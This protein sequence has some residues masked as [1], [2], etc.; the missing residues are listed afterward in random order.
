[1]SKGTRVAAAVIRMAA[2]VVIAAGGLTGGPGVVVAAQAPV[3]DGAFTIDQAAD[4]WSVYGVQCGQCHGPNL[5]GMIHAPPLSGV[6]FLNSWLGQTTDDMFAYL[7]DEM[8]PGQAGV[9]S[10]Q[11]YVDLVAYLLESN[12]AVPGDRTLMAD[13]GVPIGDAAD[14]E[15][16]RRAAG[17]GER[18]RRRSSR[19]MNQVVPQDLSPVT[20]EMLADPPPGDWLSWR[21]T[22]NSHGYS[23]L[24]Q[25]TRD[26]VADL[27]L[28]WSI[29][30]RPGNHQTTPLVHD[31]IMFLGHPGNVVQAI[32]AVTGDVIWVYRHRLPEDA[33]AGAT[34]TLA[35]YGDKLFL[36]TADANLVA[37]DA[38]T[39]EEV[40]KTVKTD[41]TQG[42]RQ[43]A[44]PVIANGVLI[45]GTNGCDRYTEQT[46]FIT[47]HDPDTGEELW[48]TSTIA[49]PGDPNDASW[50]DTPPYLRAGGDAWIPGSYDPELG[51]FYIGTAQAKP[52]VA[53]SRG[54][55]TR[56]DALYTNSTLALD[57]STGQV[58]WY[59]QHAPG[60]TLDL[61]IV[62]E[63]VLVDADGE[64]W[65]FTIGKDGILWKLDRRTGAFVDLRETVHQDIFG[66]IDKTTGELTYREDLQNIAIGERVFAC[67]SL[68]GGHNWQASAYHPGAG[69]L[70]IPLHQACM[71]LTGRAVEF[72]ELGG[73]SAG[74]Y[75][76]L[77]MPGSGGNVGKLAAYD[78]RTMEEL[79]SH[80]QRAAFLTST[81]TT[82]GGLVFA[83]D[84]D[85]YYRAFDVET[86][87]ILWETRLSAAAHGYPI[88]Y[89]A[90]GRQFLAVPASLG[91]AFRTLTAQLSPEIYQPEGGNALLRLRPAGV[92]RPHSGLR[93]LP[94]RRSKRH[95]EFV[96]M[97]GAGAATVLRSYSAGRGRM[98]AWRAQV[99]RARR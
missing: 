73:G 30:V 88:T 93:I 92:T 67:P 52:W 70:V 86:G 44:G 25:V 94:G 31:G 21:R 8:P 61:D 41:Y 98:N 5:E 22:R 85:R 42:F 43:N 13:A 49:L 51:L 47:G 59:F 82:A 80:E 36:A 71:H 65:L 4:G 20:D 75:E 33:R 10:D 76:L 29:S 17:A 1:M 28:E 32:D 11:S 58:H 78:V 68:L 57:P 55:T 69:A 39:G 63:R 64:K 90:G 37:L 18:P 2:A 27:K 7:R 23:T 83:G 60:E 3:A 26:N 96:V 16:A 19:F 97:P 35:L 81:L 56:Q 99:P 89:E 91:G 53:S 87:E 34:R 45:T 40:W 84:G 66:S 74:R 77:E 46:C 14:M 15:E 95:G 72:I 50:G 48:R 54:M 38:R 62:Y 9:I 6:D 24:D 12:G 79:W